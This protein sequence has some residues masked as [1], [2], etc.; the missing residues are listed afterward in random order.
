MAT[1]TDVAEL[2]AT[3]P[4]PSEVDRETLARCIAECFDCALSCTACA[5]RRSRRGGPLR[6]AEMHPPVPRQ[7]RCLRRHRACREPSDRI[8]AGNDE[9]AGRELPAVVFGMRPRSAS[10]TPS[11][12]STAGFAP[13]PAGV[14]RRHAPAWSTRS[15]KHIHD[16]L[17]REAAARMRPST[18]EWLSARSHHP[19]ST[20]S[21]NGSREGSRGTAAFRGTRRSTPGPRTRSARTRRYSA[22]L[23]R[24]HLKSPALGR[25]GS[26]PGSGIGSVGCTRSSVRARHHR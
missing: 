10:A 4:K 24:R 6:D 14:A 20:P 2:L 9:S 17:T 8:R 23:V 3:H 21:P 25:P 19:S 15:D 18:S 7:R 26:N 12:T 13:K 16:D 1:A 11:I 22:E 5:A